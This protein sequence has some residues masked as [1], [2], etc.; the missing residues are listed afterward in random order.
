MSPHK[1]SAMV[2]KAALW[3][4]TFFAI[5]TVAEYRIFAHEDWRLNDGQAEMSD[6]EE[7]EMGNQ[8]DVYIKNNWLFR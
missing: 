8:A 5:T 6:A 2:I 7:I 4:S 1:T 3:I